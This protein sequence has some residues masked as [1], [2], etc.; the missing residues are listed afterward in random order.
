[1]LMLQAKKNRDH[2]GKRLIIQAVSLA[3]SLSPTT[4]PAS[5]QEGWIKFA[6]LTDIDPDAHQADVLANLAHKTGVRL[7]INY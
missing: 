7:A 4:R 3:D 2:R 6:I 5:S 1:M